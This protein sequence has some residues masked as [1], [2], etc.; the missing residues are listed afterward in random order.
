MFIYENFFPGIHPVRIQKNIKYSNSM[1]SWD[2]WFKLFLPSR[3]VLVKAESFRIDSAR[4]TLST[5][6]SQWSIVEND[7]HRSEGSLN[8]VSLTFGILFYALAGSSRFAK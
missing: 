8:V 4:M 6:S 1:P 7:G 5:A 2:F 3:Q